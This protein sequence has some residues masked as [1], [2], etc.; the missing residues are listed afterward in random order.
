MKSF[1]RIAARVQE[2]ISSRKKVKHSMGI[3][4]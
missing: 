3:F 1:T 4:H 2:S